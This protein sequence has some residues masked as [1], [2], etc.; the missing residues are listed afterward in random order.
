[1]PR[2]A[3]ARVLQLLG[4]VANRNPT[5][6]QSCGYQRATGN[7]S[8]CRKLYFDTE[9]G[10]DPRYRLIYRV[11][12]DESTPQ[13]IEVITVGEKFVHNAAGNRE[14][15]YVRVGDPLNRLDDAN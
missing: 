12:P 7:L 14:S 6:G 11:L 1:M 10:V 4:E 9:T 2:D 5:L 3:K 13:T 8:D 15:I